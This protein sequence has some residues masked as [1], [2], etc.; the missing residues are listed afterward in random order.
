MNKFSEDTMYIY[1][2][3]FRQT[4]RQTIIRLHMSSLR[5]GVGGRSG[6]KE[7]VEGKRKEEEEEE[8]E[9]EEVRKE[10]VVVIIIK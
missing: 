1:V 9:E 8:E 4:D 7:W 3:H 10:E 6:W 2:S 5:M